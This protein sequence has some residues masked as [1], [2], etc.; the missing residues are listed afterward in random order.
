MYLNLVALMQYIQVK[1]LLKSGCLRNV[2]IACH[3]FK[4]IPV[5]ERGGNCICSLF[6]EYKDSLSEDEGS[7]GFPTFHDIVN[8]ST[9]CSESKYGLSTYYINS[10]MARM[11]LIT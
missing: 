7:T 8:L 10:V 5:H 2:T 3:K 6:K 9:L 11:F 4:N 1:L